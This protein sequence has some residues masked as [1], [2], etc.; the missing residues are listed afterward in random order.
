[1]YLFRGPQVVFGRKV[2][3]SASPPSPLLTVAHVPLCRVEPRAQQNQLR[4]E[5]SKGGQKSPLDRLQG[6]GGSVGG[7]AAGTA[8]HGH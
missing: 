1:M 5:S 4:V 8:A 7:G 2:E 3:A 6:Q